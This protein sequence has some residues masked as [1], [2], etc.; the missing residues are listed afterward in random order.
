MQKLRTNVHNEALVAP[1]WSTNFVNFVIILNFMNFYLMKIF[2]LKL[3]T[4]ILMYNANKVIYCLRLY[5]L[6]YDYHTCLLMLL[7]CIAM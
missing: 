2:F 4:E 7:K 5:I 3:I 1:L 6:R